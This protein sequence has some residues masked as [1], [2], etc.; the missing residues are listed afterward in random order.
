MHWELDAKSTALLRLLMS[1][2]PGVDADDPRTF[3]SYKAVHTALGLPLNGPTYGQS[4]NSH[5]MG[6]LAEWANERGYPAI[7]GL[8]TT[9]SEH[10]PE[11]GFFKF[12][13][14]DELADIPWWLQEVAKA[15]VFDWAGAIQRNIGES[16]STYPGNGNI[17]ND[18]TSSS[19]PGAI[20]RLH[21]IAQPDS[22]FFL[23]SEWGPLSDFWPVVAFSPVS[24]KSK[25]QRQY[26]SSSDFIVYTGTQGRDTS[27]EAHRSRLLS[28][29]RID[30]TRTYDT[31]DVIPPA[32]WAWAQE[33]HPG[34]WPFA[35]KVLQG[36]SIVDP[37]RSTDLIPVA[38]S[39]IGQYPYKGNVLEI[40]GAEREALLDLEISPLELTNV[41]KAHGTI[42]LNDLLK[43]KILNEEAVR[44]AALVNSRVT[45]SGTIFQGKK[46][47][48]SAPTDFILK[49]AELLRAT[50][51]TCA[52]CGGL[53][54]LK[55]AN[56]L[57]QPSP[58]R[59]DS[60]VGDYGPANFQLV[61][62]ACNLGKNSA[63]E[64]QFNEW[65]QI[66]KSG[67]EQA[68]D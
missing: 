4:L 27:E 12:Y 2:F 68:P 41:S 10:R 61:H 1:L 20:L 64:A 30:K 66:V 58:D 32:S 3:T 39:Q 65:L 45:A 35:F 40:E 59:I 15:K 57:L 53:M 38:Y 46:P 51:L 52:L 34:R 54:Y 24:L 49:V 48:R 26:R 17:G 63:T 37:P 31:S 50:P 21:D 62:L 29:V 55:P 18:S 44:I 33:N 16:S 25:I 6:L 9:E 36:W 47:D 67:A 7:T 5:G 11:K 13:G 14:K 60:K 56:R 19:K 23:K 22:K 28:L 43:D 8:I 42:S